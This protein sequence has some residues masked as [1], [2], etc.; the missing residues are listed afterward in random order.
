MET[1]TKKEP[2]KSCV[3]FLYSCNISVLGFILARMVDRLVERLVDRLV[4]RLV[5]RSNRYGDYSEV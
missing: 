1:T 4:D 3:N 5:E 2:L